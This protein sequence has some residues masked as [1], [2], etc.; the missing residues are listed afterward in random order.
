M[1]DNAALIVRSVKPHL[2]ND[3]AKKRLAIFAL[4]NVGPVDIEI[5]EIGTALI[6]EAKSELINSGV[7]R[8]ERDNQPFPLARGQEKVCLSPSMFP[9]LNLYWLNDKKSWFCIG[10]IKYR[11]TADASE[12]TTGFCR[13][14]DFGDRQWHSEFHKEFEY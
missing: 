5:A 2:E 14:W 1:D 6:A 4:A 8:F 13:K 9:E 7:L 10:Y 11:H 12:K 3:R